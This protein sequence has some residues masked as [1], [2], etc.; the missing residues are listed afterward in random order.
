MKRRTIRSVVSLAALI[1]ASMPGPS[2][3]SDNPALDRCVQ[4]FVENAVP[5]GST[6]EIRR[7]EISASTRWITGTQEKVT[8]LAQERSSGKV[9]SRASCVTHRK[10][11]IVAMYLYEAKPGLAGY[12]RPKL[13]ARHVDATQGVR[14]ASADET[15]PF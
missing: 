9:I 1:A 6:A 10:G 5:A 8:L 4:I 3:A 14:T 11:S 15:K 2:H 12:G 7:D 13:L